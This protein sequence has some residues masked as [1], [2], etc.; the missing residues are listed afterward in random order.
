MTKTKIK[1]TQEQAEAIERLKE[2]Q[3]KDF[4][5]YYKEGG[6]R[7]VS[8]ARPLAELSVVEFMGALYEGYEIEPN[9][10]I[11]D[12]IARKDGDKI[13]GKIAM[14]VKE[15]W[16]AR[17]CVGKGMSLNARNYRLATAEEAEE[18]WW[19]S[20]GREVWE[21]KK[22]DVLVGRSNGKNWLVISDISE[23]GG[24]KNYRIFPFITGESGF[25][26]IEGIKRHFQIVCFAH[27]RKDVD[28]E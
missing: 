20:H 8:W 16:D 13:R 14:Q 17:L 12:W 9:I 11:G 19:D 10:E 2:S 21:L 7:P 5:K 6:G 22:G 23:V 24:I 1:L 26:H 18:A 28:H 4:Q 3:R 25:M 15:I 27:D